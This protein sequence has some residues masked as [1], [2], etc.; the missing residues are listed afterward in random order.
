MQEDKS[1]AE[2]PGTHEAH[3]LQS[4]VPD[5]ATKLAI[6]PAVVLGFVIIVVLGVFIMLVTRGNP[7]RNGAEIA[8]AGADH[9]SLKTDTKRGNP[10]KTTADPGDD[11]TA[12]KADINARRA[13]LNRQRAAMGLPPVEGGSEPV[14]DLAKSLKK[15]ADSMVALANRLQAML[16][17]RETELSG[18]TTELLS[19]EQRY[20]D[21]AA[22][23]QSLKADLQ[24]ALVDGSRAEQL[25]RDLATMQAQRDALAAELDKV[26]QELAAKGQGVSQDEVDDLKRS[27][28]ENKKAKGF[29]ESKVRQLEGEMSQTKAKLFAASENDL[30]PAAVELFRSLR[31]LENLPEGEVAAA[32]GSLAVKLG[33][34]V[35]QTFKFATGSSELS[36]ADQETVRNLVGKI[37]DGDLVLAIGYASETGNVDKNRTLSSDRATAVAECYSSAKRPAQPVQAVYLGQTDRFG[38]R[39]P[40]A[41]QIVEIWQIRKQP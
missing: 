5:P 28:D 9:Q 29:L 33:A 8:G 13:E 31:K 27:L 10:P 18:K 23:S 30:L 38:K 34:N 17:E 37:P 2:H 26:K 40:E 6:S 15:D 25:R 36:S 22:A 1:P 35:L 4:P 21:L 24:R 7:P 12:L 41:N 39:S 16:T 19:A 11:L 3:T 14:E 32:Y 20:R